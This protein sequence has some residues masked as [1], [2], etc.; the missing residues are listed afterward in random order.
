MVQT[1]LDLSQLLELKQE[2]ILR[3]SY[4]CREYMELSVEL[5]FKNTHYPVV[6]SPTQVCMC[7]YIYIVIQCDSENQGTSGPE[8]AAQGF[9]LGN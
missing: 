5:R 2:T 9:E 6:I 1:P 7:P 4:L 3:L 8:L